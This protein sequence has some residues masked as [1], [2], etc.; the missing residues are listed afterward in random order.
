MFRTWLW[1]AR[2]SRPPTKFCSVPIQHPASRTCFISHKG[3]LHRS[4]VQ[5]LR[6]SPDR[7]VVMISLR[8]ADRLPRQRRISGFRAPVIP[9]SPFGLIHL[10]LPSPP[11]FGLPCII[12]YDHDYTNQ[13]TTTSITIVAPPSPHLHVRFCV[14]LATLALCYAKGSPCCPSYLAS[15]PDY[16]LCLCIVYY[17]CLHVMFHMSM[18]NHFLVVVPLILPPAGSDLAYYLIQTSQF[19]FLESFVFLDV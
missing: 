4:S 11:L 12:S 1:S 9:T 18:F 14:P 17:L 3:K 19:S 8:S 2:R 5:N 16:S 7:L 13:S 6:S 15:F 10:H